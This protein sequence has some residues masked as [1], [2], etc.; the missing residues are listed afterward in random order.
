[1]QGDQ[2]ECDMQNSQRGRHEQSCK[3]AAHVSRGR[4]AGAVGRL[5]SVALVACRCGV[6]ARPQL[7]RPKP[8]ISS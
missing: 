6:Q 7:L 8:E 3:R 4:V 2:H 5:G 1:M